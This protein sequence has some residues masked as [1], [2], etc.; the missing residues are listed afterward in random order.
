MGSNAFGVKKTITKYVGI[1]EGFK[2]EGASFILGDFEAEMARDSARLYKP[3]LLPIVVLQPVVPLEGPLVKET[4]DYDGATI[5]D[6]VELTVARRSL[7]VDKLFIW[8]IDR[9]DGSVKAKIQV[10]D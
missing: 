7:V 2:I 10:R 9:R 3:H 8:L 4:I 6:P 1:D 5:D